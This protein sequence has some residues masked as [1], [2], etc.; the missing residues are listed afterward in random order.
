MK[1]AS[2]KLNRAV[3]K[4]SGSIFNPSRRKDELAELCDFFGSVGKK[5][6]QLFLVAGGGAVARQYISRARLLGADESF[7]DEVGI[8]VSRLNAKL[9]LSRLGELAYPRVPISLEEVAEAASTGL[10]VALGGLHPGHSTNAVAA[11]VAER[12]HASLLVN[13]TD[14]EGVF[15]SDPAK[16][17]SAKLRTS[18]SVGDLA[19][20]MSREAMPAGTYDLMDLVSLKVIE[21]SKIPTR[22]VKCALQPLRTALE[23][24]KVGT[25]IT[26][27]N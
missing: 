27:K 20:M 19:E 22:I 2:V 4:L 16:D 10:H 17:K 5:G 9:L 15:S 24:K 12:V 8:D 18:L 21:R 26:V 14:V 13:A 23:G 3:V 25:L 11:L 6:T 1:Q 7:L